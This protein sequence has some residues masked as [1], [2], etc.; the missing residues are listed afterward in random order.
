MDG[1][2]ATSG[3]L[4]NPFTPLV[5]RERRFTFDDPNVLFIVAEPLDSGG[6]VGNLGM[7]RAPRHRRVH[8]AGIGMSVRDDW[9]GRGV[10]SALM[11]SALDVADN[12]WQLRR[13]HLEVYVDNEPA[14]ALYRKFGFEVEGT[15]RQDAFRHGEY[16]DSYVMGRIRT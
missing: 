7:H 9:Q 13:V 11:A 15:L 12:W 2:V 8:T 4:Q 6:C 16:V 5:Q 10:G 3:T 1:P 14:V